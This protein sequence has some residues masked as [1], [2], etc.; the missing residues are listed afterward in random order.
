MDAPAD[1]FLDEDRALSPSIA[2]DTM[3]RNEKPGGHGERS[4]SVGVVDMALHD[5]PAKIAGPPPLPVDLR[6][7]TATVIP[8]TPSSSTQPADTTPRQEQPRPPGR[9]RR[10]LDAGY[11]VVE[12]KIAS[13][14]LAE[15]L[16]RIEA[17]LKVLDGDGS[18]LDDDEA[19][20]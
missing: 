19:S 16:R 11:E 2:G 9:V 14:P 5:L 12:M 6:P 3:M 8:T 4:V 13:A 20:E 1:S 15:D 10:F 17:V 7:N 18:R